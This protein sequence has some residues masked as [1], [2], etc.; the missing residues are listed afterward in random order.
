MSYTFDHVHLK[1]KDPKAVADW[2]VKAFNFTI[3]NDT[4]RVFRDRVIQCKTEDGITINVSGPRTDEKLRE[5]DPTAHFGIEHFGIKVSDIEKEISR[6]TDLGATLLE[7]PI[8]VPNGPLIGFIK[9]PENVR[10]ELMQFR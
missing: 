8:D 6:L 10:I 7:G 3:F 5:G 1:A 9:A 4:T 2:Y